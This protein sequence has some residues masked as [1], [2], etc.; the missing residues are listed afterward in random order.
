MATTFP[1]VGV[2]FAANAREVSSAVTIPSGTS[3]VA[4]QIQST[5]PAWASLLGQGTG[6]YGFEYSADGGA[7][8]Q[9]L[10]G[11]DLPLGVLDRNGQMPKVGGS[12]APAVP[13]NLLR[14]WGQMPVAF[15]AQLVVTA[16]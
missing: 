14:A 11:G 16:G 9:E 1:P 12:L 2:S 8:W 15:D 6:A 10:L 13:G 3:E 4:V 7:S 5:T